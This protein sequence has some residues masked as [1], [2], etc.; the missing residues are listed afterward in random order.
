MVNTYGPTE[1]TVV[2]T[3]GDLHPER[4]VTIGNPLPGY[5][6]Y[7]LDEQLRPVPAGE[8]GELCLAGPGIA[9]GYL[10]QPEL[11]RHKFVDDPFAAGADARLY[12]T[13]DLAR[14]TAGGEIEFHGRIDSQVKVR[15]FRVE[16]AEIE[17][18]LLEAPGVR[19]AAV[20]V[21]EDLPGGGKQ[22]VG[23]LVPDRLMAINEAAVF[24]L[25][26]A[27]LPGFMVP[28]VLAEVDELPFTIG[29]KV[30]RRRLPYPEKAE[31]ID[32]DLAYHAPGSETEALLATAWA[33][34]FETERVS[35]RADFFL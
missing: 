11:T 33:A 10:D 12:R 25:L 8:D 17:A 2:A 13:G 28:V 7:I 34:V 4:P 1:A 5:Q 18:V 15:G 26:R 32:R 20:A 6:A 30:D 29:G 35:V 21:R 16:L 23:Y 27:R 9:R 3:A 22:L 14:W 31:R 19:A 24:G